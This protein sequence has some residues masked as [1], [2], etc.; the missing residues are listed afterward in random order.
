MN[1][2][3]KLLKQ[4]ETSENKY[5]TAAVFSAIVKRLSEPDKE[6]QRKPFEDGNYWTCI[7]SYGFNKGFEGLNNTEIQQGLKELVKLGYIQKRTIDGNKYYYTTTEKALS[8]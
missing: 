5:N 7:N 3:D 1:L 4:L 6:E 2:S 8:L